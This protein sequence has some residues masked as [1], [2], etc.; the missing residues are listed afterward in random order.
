MI[1]GKE[2]QG[3]FALV[4]HPIGP[5][6]LAAPMHTHERERV[7]EKSQQAAGTCSTGLHRT[8]FAAISCR[9]R[10]SEVALGRLHSPFSDTLSEGHLRAGTRIVAVKKWREATRYV[11]RYM[12][13]PE[14]FTEGLQTGRIWGIW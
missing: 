7:S 11:E 2:T 9:F 5:R 3:N 4:E 13:K 14:E 1:G 6:A 10:A 8:V 12:A